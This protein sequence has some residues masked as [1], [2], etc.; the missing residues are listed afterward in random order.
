MW[1]YILCKPALFVALQQKMVMKNL[2]D[3]VQIFPCLGFP[4]SSFPPKK[5]QKCFFL[6]FQNA[7]WRH[8]IGLKAK[9]SKTILKTAP[10]LPLPWVGGPETCETLV[11]WTEHFVDSR[12][13][14]N[15]QCFL[16]CRKD[17]YRLH[18]MLLLFAA[19]DCICQTS[20]RRITPR[21]A[22][23]SSNTFAGRF[24]WD[25]RGWPIRVSVVLV[26]NS[27]TSTCGP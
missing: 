1:C 22:E 21:T 19:G 20:K 4:Q 24:G 25:I 2:E 17:S 27:V 7:K 16:K 18:I 5:A 15:F 6:L 13:P 9:L 8:Q 26:C 11:L 14:C 3:F 23:C 12:F 10:L